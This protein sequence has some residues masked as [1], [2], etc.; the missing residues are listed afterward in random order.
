MRRLL[1]AVAVQIL[2][3]VAL[4]PRPAHAALCCPANGYEPTS[5]QTGT[6]PSCGQAQSNLTGKLRDEEIL[7]GCGSMQ[8]LCLDGPVQ[9]TDSCFTISSDLFGAS[10][11]QL[12]ECKTN[13]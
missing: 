3:L 13:C 7:E 1:L 5:T 12:Y 2:A 6:G 11:Y 10:G 8:N 9:Y 4:T